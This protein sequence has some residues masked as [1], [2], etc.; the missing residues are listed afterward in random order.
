MFRKETEMAENPK[1]ILNTLNS[2]AKSLRELDGERMTA[3]GGLS[4]A[5]FKGGKLDGK[6]KELIA[7][8]IG[9]SIQCKY[10]IVHHVYEALKAGATR[11]E[12]IEAA[13]TA[14]GMNG[15]P[16]LTYAATLFLDSVNAFAP[17]FGK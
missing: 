7:A 8:A 12:L 13:F 14:V 4:Q 5:A 9:L 15:G 6:T 2:G 17:D 3:W 11:E 16:S 10:C 1:E